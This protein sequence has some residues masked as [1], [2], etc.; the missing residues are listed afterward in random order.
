MGLRFGI[1]GISPKLCNLARN[2]APTFPS[3]L[4]RYTEERGLQW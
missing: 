1:L 3:T 2:R 4:Q